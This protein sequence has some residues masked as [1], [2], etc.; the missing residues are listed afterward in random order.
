MPERG[1]IEGGV[2]LEQVADQLHRFFWRGS[3]MHKM[4][5][6]I[7]EEAH[8]VLVGPQQYHG[9]LCFQCQRNF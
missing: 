4:Q 3:G 5:C 9:L 7:F 2:E 1:D 8:P 6:E